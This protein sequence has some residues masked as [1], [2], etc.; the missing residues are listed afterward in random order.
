M[1]WANPVQENTTSDGETMGYEIIYNTFTVEKV[2]TFM[3][4][5][6]QGSSNGY[7]VYTDSMGRERQRRERYLI[8]ADNYFIKQGSIGKGKADFNTVGEMNEY[9]DL[10]SIQDEMDSG[11]LQGRYT[12]AKGMLNSF[13]RGN[14]L[15]DYGA[16][17][18][19]LKLVSLYYMDTGKSYTITDEEK[20]MIRNAFEPINK[21]TEILTRK[22]EFDTID[23][24]LM[25]MSEDL[26]K[27]VLSWRSRKNLI[28]YRCNRRIENL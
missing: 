28:E 13:K 6:V 2:G 9:F 14:N 3:P 20:N 19:T 22:E 1:N 16:V 5:V 10:E 21:E 15:F 4:F 8:K 18:T 27:K 25:D 12:T 26:R 17:P 24:C 11:T 23:K 7:Q